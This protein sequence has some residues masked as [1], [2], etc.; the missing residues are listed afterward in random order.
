MKKKA[1]YKSGLNSYFIGE[2]LT[3]A[4]YVDQTRDMIE[5]ARVDLTD[6]NREKIIDTNAPFEWCPDAPNAR[7]PQSKKIINGVLLVHGLFD[8]PVMMLSLADYFKKQQFLVRAILLPGHGTNPGD[9]LDVSYQEW[10]KATH[11]GIQSF[12]DEVEN[13]FLCG[14]STGGTL[15]LHQ[16]LMTQ[17]KQLKGLILFAPAIKLH[18]PIAILSNFDTLL[19]RTIGG[20]KWYARSANPDYAKYSSFTLSSP[21][22]LHLLTQIINRKLIEQQI[23]A[24]IFLVA[25]ANDEA[26]SVKAMMQF[27]SKH[28][29]PNSKCILYS[30]NQEEFADNRIEIISSYLPEKH[31]LN[32][33]HVC[34]PI[35]PDHPHYG[36]QGDYEDRL[37]YEES[38]TEKPKI[39]SEE[40]FL[41]AVTLTSLRQHFLRRLSF[42]PDFFNLLNKIDQFLKG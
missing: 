39:I 11:F 14:F 29:N 18:A 40:I 31:I 42:N 20:I 28:K 21:H 36:E 38:I 4:A 7:N 1:F 19:H 33:S 15:L 25:T 5:A 2:N 13:L 3:F 30:S 35:A 37:H 23:N 26:L 34:L 9:L 27:F 10:L 32:F 22:Q 12:A 8:S 41:G 17:I 24:P 6:E 16:A